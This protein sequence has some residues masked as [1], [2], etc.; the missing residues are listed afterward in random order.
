ML[1]VSLINGVMM[2]SPHQCPSDHLFP[3]NFSHISDIVIASFSVSICKAMALV[4]APRVS[5]K[6][7][8]L[9]DGDQIM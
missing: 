1:S 6:H 5:L 3:T 2:I 7:N 4:V 8:V 9:T